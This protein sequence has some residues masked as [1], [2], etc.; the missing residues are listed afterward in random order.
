MSGV[1]F[2]S[3]ISPA[4]SQGQLYTSSPSSRLTGCSTERALKRVRRRKALLTAVTL[5]PDQ[6]VTEGYKH[7]QVGKA[8]LKRGHDLATTESSLCCIIGPGATS[9]VALVV[10]VE[11]LSLVCLGVEQDSPAAARPGN[12][13]RQPGIIHDGGVIVEPVEVGRRDVEPQEI[14]AKFGPVDRLEVVHGWLELSLRESPAAP[15]EP[16]EI[17]RGPGRAAGRM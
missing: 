3:P 15:A 10:E 14:V 4:A 2:Q 12:L 5:L 8:F 7:C 1:S 11:E 13:G 6:A 17:L 9:G 16:G